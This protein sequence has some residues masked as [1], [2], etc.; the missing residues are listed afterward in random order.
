MAVHSQTVSK[1]YTAVE[2]TTAKL[3]SNLITP[4]SVAVAVSIVFSWFSPIGV[5]PIMS[6][7]SSAL[8]GMLTL[9]LAPF[10]PVAYSARTG[11]TDLDVSDVSKRAPLYVPGI[12]SYVGAALVFLTLDNKIM[13]VIAFAYV[14]V[15]LA[16]FLITLVWKISAH[17]AGIAGPTT[18]LVF[19]FG[20][21]VLP[22]YVLSILMIW[23]RVKL[24]A[25]TPTQAVAGIVVAI[26]ITSLVYAV[27][28]P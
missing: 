25:H 13:F 9:C 19:V 11:R 2:S 16:T 21:W 18:A 5:G 15:T 6:P 3:Y 8:I 24:R 22:L 1:R 27:F 10:L 7:S 4:F 20:L 26:T 28:Y 23:S 14:C 17:T 12:V